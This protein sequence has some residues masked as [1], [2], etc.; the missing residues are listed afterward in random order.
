MLT[1]LPFHL[2]KVGHCTHPECM[3]MR[4]GSLRSL[5]F[6]ALCGLLIHPQRGAI[7]FDTGYSAHFFDATRVLPERAYRWVTPVAMAPEE[8][9][10]AQLAR[11]GIAA[12]EVRRIVISHYHGDHI[13]GLKA[14]PNARF[15]SMRDE[16][17]QLRSRSRWRNLMHGHLPQLLPADFSARL[18]FA[19]DSAAIDL[20]PALWPFDRGY[21]LLGDGSVLGVPLPGHTRG[22]MGLLFRRSGGELVLLAADACWSMQALEMQRPPTWL[23]S[24]LFDDTSRYQATFSQL[25][26]LA[27]RAS[28]V[29]IVP[30]HCDLTWRHWRHEPA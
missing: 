9:L 6:P 12:S 26:E 18:D 17:L 11:L 14:F 8:A 27:L 3:A 13:A 29:C 22:Q 25:R 21:D 4:G 16:Y 24:R 2:L 19:D 5:R 23:A 15:V 28:G 7:L 20:P 10:P 30:S 1:P